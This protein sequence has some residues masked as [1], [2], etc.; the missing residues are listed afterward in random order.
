MSGGCYSV[1][2]DQRGVVS[3]GDVEE[4]D[5]LVYLDLATRGELWLRTNGETP[6]RLLL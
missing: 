1:V 4:T 3:Y 6:G 2:V 5:R